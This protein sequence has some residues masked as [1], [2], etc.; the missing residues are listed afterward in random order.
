MHHRFFVDEVGNFHETAVFETVARLQEIFPL[1]DVL[2]M[3]AEIMMERSHR[4][5]AGD[6]DAQWAPYGLT[7]SRF[8]LLRMLYSTDQKRL[9]MGQI[10]SQMNLEPNNVTQLTAALVRQG[11]ILREAAQD[12]RRVVYAVLTE[13]GSQLFETVM[14]AGAQR[15]EDAFS[16]L[17]PRE[18]QELTHLLS[19]LRMHLLA[20]ASR[21]ADDHSSDRNRV[22]QR[23]R[24]R[25]ASR[26]TAGEGSST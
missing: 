5:M 7:G 16:A 10:A 3:E 22:K 24:R 6:R 21:L 2:S 23:S 19:K 20:S 4:L 13:K 17:T 9:T 18:R 14:E 1:M 26:P 12:D 25:S 15:V 8:I 11:L